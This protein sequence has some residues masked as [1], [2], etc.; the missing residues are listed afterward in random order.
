[1]PSYSFISSV[2]YLYC[3]KQRE[4]HTHKAIM[5]MQNKTKQQQQKQYLTQGT[6]RKWRLIQTFIEKEIHNG[7]VILIHIGIL[8]SCKGKVKLGRWMELENIIV[9]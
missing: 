6:A 9:S 5:A 3:T 7:N 1:M 8:C 2:I 4:T